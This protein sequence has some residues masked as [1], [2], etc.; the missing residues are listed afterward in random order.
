MYGHV[1]GFYARKYK[2]CWC[3]KLFLCVFSY[4]SY[5]LSPM[6]FFCVSLVLLLHYMPKVF[7][8]YYFIHRV[9]HK[10]FPFSSY[11]SCFNRYQKLSQG[12]ARDWGEA[13]E[14]GRR[15]FLFGYQVKFFPFFDNF[16]NLVF[17]S[18]LLSYWKM[19]KNNRIIHRMLGWV[20][21]ENQD[22]W[23]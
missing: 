20:R 5:F 19:G 11:L 21:F 8:C 6:L 17:P 4:Q 22:K 9:L 16:P 23:Q 2:L 3:Y 13:W 18:P 15:I 7:L 1:N 12:E 14:R 10:K